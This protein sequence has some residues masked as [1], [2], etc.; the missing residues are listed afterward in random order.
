MLAMMDYK[1]IDQRD[2]RDSEKDAKT[3]LRGSICGIGV[4]RGSLARAGAS[5]SKSL[6]SKRASRKSL[7]CRI[8]LV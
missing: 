1:N 8:D 6:I 4:T 2:K 3:E 5:I 7:I